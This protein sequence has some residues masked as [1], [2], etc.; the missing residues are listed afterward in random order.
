VILYAKEQTG[1]KFVQTQYISHHHI[2][3]NFIDV[4]R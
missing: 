1:T 4:N 2:P 3:D